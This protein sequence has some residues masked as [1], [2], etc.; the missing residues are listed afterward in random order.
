LL[1]FI[2]SLY[3]GLNRLRDSEEGLSDITKIST[4]ALLL[5]ALQLLS[6]CVKIGDFLYIL[7][8]QKLTINSTS[9]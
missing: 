2:G 3:D 1:P 7:G 6:F 8:S 9:F 4:M 5:P